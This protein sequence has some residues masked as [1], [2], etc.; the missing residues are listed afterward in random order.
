MAIF[1][2]SY[3]GFELSVFLHYLIIQ[4]YL[5]RDFFIVQ[6]LSVL[7]YPGD[8]TVVAIIPRSKQRPT[9]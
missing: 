4:S 2:H 8:F 1:F 6:S 7:V 3:F 9:D 5:D